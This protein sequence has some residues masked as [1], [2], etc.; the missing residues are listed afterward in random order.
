[1]KYFYTAFDQENKV[2]R[3]AKAW[4]SPD[5]FLLSNWT[6][7]TVIVIGLIASLLTFIAVHF[8]FE[9]H[10]HFENRKAFVPQ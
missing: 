3:I 2:I 6:T 9:P 8:I 4:H 1:M 10:R 7:G 5:D